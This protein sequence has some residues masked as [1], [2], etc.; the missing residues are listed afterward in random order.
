VQEG[1]EQ[2]QE[3]HQALGL[4]VRDDFRGRGGMGIA[5]WFSESW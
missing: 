5:A 1:V 2:G 3:Q 4:G